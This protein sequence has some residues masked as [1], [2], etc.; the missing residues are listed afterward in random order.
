MSFFQRFPGAFIYP[1]RGD[2]TFALIAGGVFFY[3]LDLLSQYSFLGIIVT[4]FVSG[5]YCA[6]ML[7]IIRSS[8]CDENQLP[9]WPSFN[10][11]QEDIFQPLVYVVGTVLFCA[12]PAGLYYFIQ[13][14]D[15]EHIDK[16]FWILAG[17]GVLYFPMGLLAVAVYDSL[18]GLNPLVI[19]MSIIKIPFQ[20]IL[21]LLGFMMAFAMSVALTVI[22]TEYL[23]YVNGLIISLTSLYFTAVEMRILGILYDSN[24]DR[25]QWV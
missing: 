12:L 5:Y 3:L 20:Y 1:F 21:A 4:A 17:L 9:D 16:V 6:F 25:L 23:P 24:R 14:H 15:K 13:I 8:V 19:I 10:N 22:A 2:G 11:W 7:G 18:A